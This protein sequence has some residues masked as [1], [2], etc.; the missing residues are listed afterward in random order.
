[1]NVLYFVCQ[2]I[3]DSIT[4]YYVLIFLES[5]INLFNYLHKKVSDIVEKNTNKEEN[6]LKVV[7]IVSTTIFS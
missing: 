6:N 2:H 5:E 1:M 4:T 3:N 7:V